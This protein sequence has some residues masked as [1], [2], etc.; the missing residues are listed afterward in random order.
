VSR[1]VLA[2][3]IGL[4]GCGPALNSA[5]QTRKIDSPEVLKQLL[6]M[7]A[8]TP[9]NGATPAPTP[10]P[11]SR[12]FDFYNK[13]NTPPDDAPIEDLVDYWGR[14]VESDRRPSDAVKKRLLEACAADPG[15]LSSFL[16]FLPD[17]D[18]TAAK[19]KNIFDKV[20]TDPKIDQ[21]WRERVRN[22]LVF[23]SAY[24]LDELVALAQKTKDNQ[25]DGA[26]DKED[27]LTSLAYVS[28]SHAEP[29]L[30][31]LMASG[32]PRASA[33]AL[34]LYYEHAVEE[35]D[36]ANEE[37]YRRDLQAIATNPHQ[38]AYARNVAIESLSL[39]EWSGRDDWYLGLFQDQT[40]LD[41]SD[42]EYSVTPLT[43]LFD[44]DLEKWIPVMT[45]LLESKDMNVR[46]AAASCLVRIDE[47]EES[48]KKA[49]TPLLPWLTNPAWVNDTGNYR[50]RLIQALGTFKIPE[51][52]PG[53]ISVVENDDSQPGF[54]RGFAAQS[55]SQYQDA[56][57]VPALKRA[58]AKEKDEAQRYRIV[59]GLLACN[60]LTEKEQLEALEEYA[61]KLTSEESRADT[62]RYRGPNEEPLSVKLSLGKY[63]GQSRETPSDSLV[64]AVLARA[65]ELKTENAALASALLDITHMWQG[66][67]IELDIIRRIG[68][69]SAD[70]S[71]IREALERREKMREGLRTELQG[72]ASVDGAAQAVGAVLLNDATLAQGILNSEDRLAQVALLACSRL[73]QMPLPVEMV[74]Q[75]LRHKD[76]LLELAAE[77]YLLAEDS[78]EAREILWRRHPNEAFITGWREN[79]YLG[80]L[81]FEGLMKSEEQ[82]RAEVLKEN[83]PIEILAFMYNLTDRGAVVRI[84]PDKAVFTEHED[85]ARYRE[86]TVS[87][88]EIAVLKDFIATKGFADRGPTA[89]YCHH[90]CLTGELLLLTKEKGRR[91]FN[92]G[93][94]DDWFELLDQFTQLG[95]HDATKV[96]YKL[97]EEIKGLEVLY[98]GELTVNDIA[99][100]GGELRLRVERDETKQENEERLATY[101]ANEDDD[102]ELALQLSRRRVE[103]TAARVSW[104][105]FANDK[106]GAIT[107]QPD[108]YLAVDGLRFVSGDENDVDWE[109]S[110]MNHPQVIGPDSI[111]FA[112]NYANLFRQFAGGKPVVVGSENGAYASPI[113]TRDGKWVIATKEG[114]DSEP[115]YIVRLNLLTGREFRVNIPAADNLF[116][117]GFIPPLGQVLVKRAKA[118]Y[119]GAGAKVKGPEKPEYYL[120]DPATGIA[121]LVTGEFKPLMYSQRFLQAT[122]KPDEFWAAISDEKKNQTQIGRYSLKDFSF[123]PTMTVPQLTFDSKAIWVDAAQKKV[124]VVY[125]GQLLRLP[126]QATD[127]PAS[128]TKK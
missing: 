74:N 63:L 23:N 27:A 120:V 22:W 8:P 81:S 98:A 56:R 21:D 127:A 68:N 117:V 119:M 107:T 6:A 109:N 9:R 5:G 37:R 111:I 58:L 113:V 11:D 61:S 112:Q 57:A 102:E 54:P 44:S 50:L 105:V 4:F 24:Y 87:A 124:Y 125:K 51:S 17:D 77:T 122:E 66:Q 103:I 49:L 42:G 13:T 95:N 84:Y 99:Q 12:P 18:S 96:H 14:W 47:D 89:I 108:S 46:T 67:Q 92:Q 76:S 86:R 110:E 65:E 115:S 53:L 83:G 40:L 101:E 43:T 29:M 69:G 104:R 20:Q 59:K 116:P 106:L 2:I 126:L 97:E 82:L 26:V 121:R 79:T 85:P 48:A 62:I 60:G 28:W 33:L 35:K 25:R 88:G 118:D 71:T 16:N 3:V 34:T 100:Q 39:T 114:E 94:F 30:R 10:L 31:G 80:P 75:V 91:V 73:T 72:L 90:G 70:S 38:P 52:V 1:I 78:Q 19:V 64:S 32:Q 36:L 55:L 128:V 45:R 41:P 93:G 15:I 123:K 7:P